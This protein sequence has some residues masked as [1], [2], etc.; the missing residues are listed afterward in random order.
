MPKIIAATY[1][2]VQEIG[3]GGGGI[4]YLAHHMRLGKWVVL[5][6][7]RRTLAARPE[8][9]RREVDALKNLSHT[10]IPQVYD[11][12][13]EN[14][15]VYTVMDYIEGE[16]LDKPL[17]RGERFSQAEVIEWGCQLLEAICYLH[18]RPPNGILHADIKPANVMLTPQGDIRLIDFN[19]ALALGEEGAVRVG[20]SRGYASPEHYGVDYTAVSATQGVEDAATQLSVT[21][22]ETVL[23]NDSGSSGSGRASKRT[24]YLDARSDIYSLGATLYHLLTGQRPA[25]DAREVKPIPHDVCSSAVAAIIK[26]AM[27]PDP[28][29]RY[30]SAAEMLDAFEHLHENDP[31]TKRHKRISAAAACVLTATFLIGGALTFVGLKQLERTQNAYALAEY[32]ADALHAG[33]VEGAV[34]QALAAL[35]EKRGIFDPPYTP[36]AQRALSN[37]LGVYDL[38]DG[39]RAHLSIALPASPIKTALSPEGTRLAALTSGLVSVFDTESGQLLAKLPANSSALSDIVFTDEHTM[40]Y[41]GVDALRAYDLSAS[42]ELWAGEAATSIS[43]SADDSTAATVYRDE[44]K[45]VVY[46]LDSGTVR[47]TVDFHGKRQSVAYN[48]SF[49]DPEDSL[50]ALNGDGTRLAVSFAD[51]GL[52]LFD[53]RDGGSDLEIFDFSEFTHFEGGFFGPYFAFSATATDQSI[54]AVIDLTTQTQ[55]GGFAA[56]TPFH[57]RA[58]ESG[59]YLSAE[60][61]LVRLD[62]ISGEQTELAY[63]GDDITAFTMDSGYTLTA[64]TAAGCSFFDDAARLLE[65]HTEQGRCDLIQLS[66]SYAVTASRDVPALRVM[67]AETHSEAQLF[68]YDPAFL[69]DEARIS[70]DGRTVMLFRYDAFRLLSMEGTLLAE[71][72]LPDAERV[73]DQQYRREETGSYLE[74]IYYSGLRQAW[75]AVDGTLLWEKHGD[76]ADTSLEDVFTTDEL[77]ILSPLHGTPAAYD[78]KTGKLVRELEAEDYL[79]YVT[80]VGSQIITEYISA[81]GQRYGLLLDGNCNV[82]AELPCLCDILADGTLVFDDMRGNLRQGRIYSTQELI[83]LGK[84]HQGGS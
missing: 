29:K 4:V 62:P 13:Q 84:I 72:M 56:E 65:T 19:I 69:H 11:F 41:A 67:K 3:S 75:S 38:A 48:D 80:Q 81:Q 35:P 27:E 66:G 21:G 58:D 10:Y 64:T 59:I 51:G 37:A 25:Q 16:S 23:T 5:K 7:D 73:Y 46:D 2:I 9:L 76:A 22:P 43:L 52:C 39:F 57:V 79:T 60:N 17:S 40:L 32:S 49:A 83:A 74:V 30:Q 34:A 61:L 45:A 42:K 26:K 54:F 20:F 53:L 8:V 33:D 68:T 70:A 47:E 36:Q 6:A 44:S 55:T 12:V 24:I 78:L 14:G 1:K 71:V 18:S 82:L 77:Q 15:V 50:L 63:T 31:R 28:D